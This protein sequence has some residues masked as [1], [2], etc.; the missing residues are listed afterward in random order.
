MRTRP[1]IQIAFAEDHEIVRKGVA[2]LINNMEGGFN[3]Y[4]EAENGQELL[5]KIA[6]GS[7]QP[8]IA[9]LDISMP[10][11]NGFETMVHLKSKYPYIRVLILTMID[12]D[13][14]FTILKMMQL[15]A[16]GYIGKNASPRELE[17]ALIDI[18]TEG[19]Y[20]STTML[21]KFPD[22][23]EENMQEHFKELLTEADITFLSQCCSSLT[24]REI[25]ETMGQSLRTVENH[26]A[27]LCEKLNIH[28]RLE[29]GMYALRAGFGKFTHPAG[30][31]RAVH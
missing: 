8:Y 25:A 14:E 26:A 28:S 2:E 12:D 15:G 5:D 22:M 4:I 11:M 19:Y 6:A 13:N 24:Y 31:L 17:K 1:I 18:Y 16:R 10:V 9:V 30:I 3:V 21:K 23:N 7:Y 27:K 20:F 29:L